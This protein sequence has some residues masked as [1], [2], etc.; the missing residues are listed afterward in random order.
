VRASRTRFPIAEQPLTLP[1]R[2]IEVPASDAG[3]RPLAD[4]VLPLFGDHDRARVARAVT[5]E[6]MPLDALAG[7]RL[8]D[9]LLPVDIVHIWEPRFPSDH[10]AVTSS[11][12]P[13]IP[14]T[15]GHVT[16]LT[17]ESRCRL[18]VLT[19]GSETDAH[20]AR[21][22]SAAV[23]ARG[24]PAMLVL[25][26]ESGQSTELAVLYQ[27]L[28]HN[29]PLD[30]AARAAA[31][32]PQ[33]LS[34]FAG[35]GREEGVRFTRLG[36]ELKRIADDLLQAPPG[37]PVA[38]LR[39]ERLRRL[40]GS[41]WPR[42]S[43]LDTRP[44]NAL[45]QFADAWPNLVFEQHEGAGLLPLTDSV[46]DI[47]E[48][49]FVPIQQQQQQQQQQLERPQ[50]ERY[51]NSNVWLDRGDEPSTRLEQSTAR[52]SVH[53][54]Y[55]LEIAI[56]PKD[57][58]VKT[59]GAAPLKEQVFQWQPSARGAWLEVAVTALDCEIWGDPVR[60]LWLPGQGESDSVYFAF[61]PTVAPV[62]RLRFCIYY[63]QN[64]IQSFRIAFL[65][66]D[67]DRD[68][69]TAEKRRE[70]MAQ[71][72]G[73]EET[74]VRDFGFLPRLEYSLG[75][76]AEQWT[77]RPVRALS[78]VAN[79][80]D[81]K[82]IITVKGADS[83]GVAQPGN[84]ES[85][86]DQLRTALRDIGTSNG[87]A[88][89]QY[90]FGLAGD[91]N[92]G[93]PEDLQ[94][95]LK[96]LAQKGR[97]LYVQLF[98]DVTLQQKIEKSL[99]EPCVIHVAHVLAEKVLPWSV[100]Y[101]RHYDAN[102]PV[103]HEACT[104]ALAETPEAAIKLKCREHPHCLLHPDRLQERV[105]AGHPELTPEIVACPLHFWG[106]RHVIEVPA[107]Q[108]DATGIAPPEQLDLIR[109]RQTLHVVAA[110]HQGLGL[111][112]QHSQ[113]IEKLFAPP[114]AALRKD[115]Q[116]DKV[117]ALLDD[118]QIDLAYFYCHARGGAVGG[119][120]YEEFLEL[121]TKGDAQPSK[122]APEDFGPVVWTHHPMVI[123]NGCHTAGFSPR[124]LS[125]FVRVFMGRHA[126]GV[127]GTEIDVWE[128]LA[129]EF[130]QLF[131]REF[132]KGTS[133]GDALRLARLALLARNNPLGL[134]YTLYAAAQLALRHPQS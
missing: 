82:P 134:V 28:I 127:I 80:L 70:L 10:E 100:L 71:A 56:G 108:V 95:A 19:C 30:R 13:E 94:D 99:A 111:V 50:G 98:S 118:S 128:E 116:R 120:E 32:R 65:T 113:D 40:V 48:K 17:Q 121:M 67:T 96:E 81:G 87:A 59:I 105:A 97:R 16:R 36:E 75:Q 91:A 85:Y 130:V 125:P 14:C 90:R 6:P 110:L 49:V 12:R 58:R 131:A 78:V 102:K 34:L 115:S 89:E 2:I 112:D 42:M 11:S 38:D 84:V 21:L 31:R 61:Q 106:F 88:G 83:F 15:L 37:G 54:L 41:T 124:A 35:G 9:R 60:D 107:Q 52:L 77:S 1:L 66:S 64:V 63:Q 101:D 33:T 104:A 51:V 44:R 27:E 4:I 119:N 25:M 129:G 43:P 76:A 5:I 46:L 39:I 109:N 93:K 122:I 7:F 72:L 126:G 8:S 47:R 73:I 22:L 132:L 86:V 55:H 123:I 133:A 68:E 45:R 69:P 53:E 103:P 26:P 74:A 92:R 24:G 29:N 3:T 117:I 20:K 79:D 23:V 57:V 62:A 114:L 18:I